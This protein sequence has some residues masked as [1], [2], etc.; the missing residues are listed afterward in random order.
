MGITIIWGINEEGCEVNKLI[1]TLIS[2]QN[3]KKIKEI[4]E[5]ISFLFDDFN[6]VYKVLQMK[7]L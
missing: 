1:M 3:L 7:V 6:K 5:K 4:R 2:C